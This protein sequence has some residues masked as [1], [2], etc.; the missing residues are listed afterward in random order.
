[1]LSLKDNSFDGRLLHK[2]HY[3]VYYIR[4]CASL[5][6]SGDYLQVTR[7]KFA[8]SDTIKLRVEGLNSVVKDFRISTYLIMLRL[9]PIQPFSP[10]R[11]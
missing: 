4:Y 10:K 5:I 6:G 1:M 3:P 11:Q 9:S 7:V 2:I 8:N